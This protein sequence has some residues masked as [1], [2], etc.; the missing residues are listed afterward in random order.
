MAC[1]CPTFPRSATS[2]LVAIPVRVADGAAAA[3]VTRP[4]DV[5]DVLATGDLTGADTA[6][7]A[8]VVA[9]SVTVLSVPPHDAGAGDD[10]G[11][12]VVAVTPE[13]AAAVATAAGVRRLSLVLRRP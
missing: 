10:A 4:G 9:A 5:V 1:T 3:A 7:P 6:A 11:L 2:G 8:V 12:V 13:Q